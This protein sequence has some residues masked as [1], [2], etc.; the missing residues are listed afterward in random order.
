APLNV[1]TLRAREWVLPLPAKHCIEPKDMARGDGCLLIAAVIH[2]RAHGA[3]LL[4]LADERRSRGVQI[5]VSQIVRVR[6]A[7]NIV[8][9]LRRERN[10][11]VDR[12]VR[13]EAGAIRTVSCEVDG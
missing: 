4:C 7:E 5:P 13:P 3:G 12:A 9:I 2:E 6:S 10:R 11:G 1:E 8:E